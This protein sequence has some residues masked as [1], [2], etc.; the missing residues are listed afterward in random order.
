MRRLLILAAALLIALPGWAATRVSVSQLDSL[1]AE[2]HTQNKGD[3]ATRNKLK[4]LELTEQLTKPVMDSFTKYQPGP[5]TIVQIRVL[6]LER[7][8][9]P[10]P[11]TNLPDT[12]APDQATL[13][14]MMS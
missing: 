13:K 10:P 8:L 2:M 3:E 14:A 12:P 6:A 1:L 7:A 4:E 11:A 5:E 9:L